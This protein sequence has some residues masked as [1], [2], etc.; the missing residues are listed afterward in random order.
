MRL[1]NEQTAENRRQILEAAGRLFREHGFAGVAVADLM[2]AAG[3]THGGFYNHFPSKDAIA[4]EACATVIARS[5]A[6]L[7]EKLGQET[8][9]QKTGKAWQQ[10][11]DRYL[12]VEHRDAPASGCAVSA[13]AADAARQ[14][15][16][17]QTSFAEGIENVIGI[18]AA[19]LP[20]AKHDKGRTSTR[21]RAMRLWSEMVGAL[22]LSRAVTDA[23]PDLSEE[24]LASSRRVV[25]ANRG[26]TRSGNNRSR[27]RVFR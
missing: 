17:V 10:Y 5:N 24:I 2:K 8:S 25:Q 6:D 22:V 15:K 11:L 19:N 1:T 27:V 9:D 21:A 13:L 20:K 16:E 23:D 7:A 26:R 4:A 3:F 18:L 12:S 14:S